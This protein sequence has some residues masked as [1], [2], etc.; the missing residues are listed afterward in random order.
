MSKEIIDLINKKEEQIKK[1]QEEIVILK[2]KLE[3]L[4]KSDKS[5]TIFSKE[6]K[7]NLF[8]NYFRGRD[9]TYPYLSIDKNNPSKKYYI[10]ACANE[11]KQGVCNKLMKKPCKTCQYRENKPLTYEVYQN[12]NST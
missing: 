4:D 11:W 10:P 2:V 9:D 12:C 3:T 5:T 1:L 6:E 8:M 7:V